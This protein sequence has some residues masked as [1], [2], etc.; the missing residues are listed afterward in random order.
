[1]TRSNSRATVHAEPEGIVFM[2]I[3]RRARIPASTGL[4][5]GVKRT[6]AGGQGPLQWQGSPRRDAQIDASNRRSP[7]GRPPRQ[8]HSRPRREHLTI[9]RASR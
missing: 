7:K 6:D 9:P 4:P 2:T 5:Q 8:A 3:A 1:M